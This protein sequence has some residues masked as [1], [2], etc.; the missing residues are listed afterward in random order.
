MEMSQIDSR[1]DPQLDHENA[2]ERQVTVT[3]GVIIYNS[4]NSS[5]S[6]L[7]ETLRNLQ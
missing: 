6:N 4:Q 3:V 5:S 2:N 7:F 1:A